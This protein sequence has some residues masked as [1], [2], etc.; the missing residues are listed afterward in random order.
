MLL[1]SSSPYNNCTKTRLFTESTFLCNS[2]WNLKISLSIIKAMLSW[3]ILDFLRSS[4]VKTVLPC[5]FVV[6]P[7]I[8]PLKLSKKWVMV[9]T[10]IGGVWAAWFMKWLQDSHLIIMKTECNFSSLSS[11]K[12]LMLAKYF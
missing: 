7:N 11:I 1:K 5:Q 10:S 12:M 4:I 6:H 3:R 9:L 2:V 8:L